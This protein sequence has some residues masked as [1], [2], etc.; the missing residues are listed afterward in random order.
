MTAWRAFL[1]TVGILHL[2]VW[3]WLFYAMYSLRGLVSDEPVDPSLNVHDI[4]GLTP[5]LTYAYYIVLPMT[6]IRA[7]TAW[8][9]GIA[10]HIPVTGH[11]SYGL[12]HSW[13]ALILLIGP[14][15]WFLYMQA[16]TRCERSR[17]E[18]I[19]PR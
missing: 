19:T 16:L 14:V 6:S 2:L 9:A 7:H 12:D 13:K 3:A 18:Q 4:L 11:L 15:C 17:S 10:F 8:L 5:L 1:A